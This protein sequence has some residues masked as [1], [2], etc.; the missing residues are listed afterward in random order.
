V[1][2]DDF[3]DS[4]TEYGLGTNLASEF[5]GVFYLAELEKRGIRHHPCGVECHTAGSMYAAS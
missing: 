4:V 2:P 1:R 5:I 3:D